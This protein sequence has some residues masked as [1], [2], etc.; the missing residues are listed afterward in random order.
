[1]NSPK[2]ILVLF[3]ESQ[4]AP[5][6]C[7]SL[8]D[9]GFEVV[10]ACRRKHASPLRRSRLVEVRDV[11][12]PELDYEHTMRDIQQHAT[13]LDVEA[14]LPLDDTSLWLVDRMRG[15]L[16]CVVAVPSPSAVS[17]AL[18]KRLQIDA[19]REAGF[20]IPRT[21]CPSTAKEY[22]QWTTFPCIVKGALAARPRGAAI[23][24]GRAHFCRDGAAYR[25]LDAVRSPQESMVVQEWKHGVGVGVFGF[26]T[27]DGVRAWSGHHRIRMMNPAG[28]GSSCCE[29]EHPSPETRDRVERLLA[30][31]DWHGLFMIELL[32]DANGT[33]WFIELNGRAWGSTALARAC[34]LEYPRWAVQDALGALPK[35]PTSSETRPIR[36]R[37][38]G[39]ELVHLLFV[40]RG[41]G[42]HAGM[43]WPQRFRTIRDLCAVGQSTR[44][45][46]ARRGD[47]RV[48]VADAF[49]SVLSQVCRRRGG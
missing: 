26:R 6:A 38:L 2:R 15:Q 41:S 21:F 5:E 3:G 9:G 4:A 29:S 16:K 48:F 35:L 31:I 47:M 1:M 24:R 33:E 8:I 11:A 7:Y 43:A 45:Y 18:D 44:W 27:A 10:V 49:Q 40:L 12:E 20:N 25:G 32:R 13:E 42:R 34:G 23:G 17:V 22:S 36:A 14:V 39:R 30:S 19:A 46:N 28:S 37:N